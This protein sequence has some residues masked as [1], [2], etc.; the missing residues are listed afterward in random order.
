MLI[1]LPFL[2]LPLEMFALLEERSYFFLAFRKAIA[3][4]N[5]EMVF[6]PRWLPLIEYV[7]K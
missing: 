1:L 2:F 7:N 6:I 4:K 5:P 3:V